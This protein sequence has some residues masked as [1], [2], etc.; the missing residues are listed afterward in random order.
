MA[1]MLFKDFCNDY[2]TEIKTIMT[3]QN[4]DLNDNV[5]PVIDLLKTHA[6][7]VLQL[8]Y[9]RYMFDD[10]RLDEFCADVFTGFP[11]LMQQLSISRVLDGMA[12]V[13]TDTS[14]EITSRSEGLTSDVTQESEL[15]AG[16]TQTSTD[17]LNTQQATTGTIGVTNDNT[18]LQEGTTD[19]N[20]TS[21]VAKTGGKTVNLSHQMPEQAIDGMTG[22]FPV[23]DQGTPN[24]AAAYVQTAAENFN[25]SNPISTTE[26]SNQEVNSSITDSGET[27]TTNN[28]TVADTG[29]NT[30]TRVNSGSDTTNSLT[31]TSQNVTI[32]EERTRTETNKQFAYEFKAFL[33]SVESVNA[34]RNWEL[35]FAW[36]CGII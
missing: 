33:E 24:L 25:T 1:E 15:T 16:T 34:F 13:P 23:D 30:Q 6:L 35:S 7:S 18:R 17:V 20:N 22:D 3:W 2:E 10:E 29:T 4:Y 5:L 26:T 21:T 31:N 32:D 36:V 14:S 8:S 9:G 19:I 27:V 11:I 12:I 28:V